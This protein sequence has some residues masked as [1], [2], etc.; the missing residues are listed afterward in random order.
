MLKEL[1]ELKIELDNLGVNPN[2][3]AIDELPSYEG[4]CIYD[5]RSTIEVF[6]FERGNR[7]NTKNFN[8]V[9]EAV[10]YFKSLVLQEPRAK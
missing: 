2:Y 7:F 3:Y 6:Y 4:F 1:E 5:S 8:D 9:E 10:K